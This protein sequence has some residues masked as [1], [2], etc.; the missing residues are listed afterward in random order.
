MTFLFLGTLSRRMILTIMWLGWNNKFWRDW[1]DVI[2]YFLRNSNFQSLRLLVESL[3][4]L[5]LATMI[6]EVTNTKRR[7]KSN[8]FCLFITPWQ[9]FIFGDDLRR[10]TWSFKGHTP[11]L[12]RFG[13]SKKY[14]SNYG[15][16]IKTRSV[17]F[18]QKKIH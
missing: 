5:K 15:I 17:T 16:D 14:R 10:C 3:K 9:Q 8:H 6:S 4:L 1:I 13:N 11:L 2:L 12:A 7:L 18:L